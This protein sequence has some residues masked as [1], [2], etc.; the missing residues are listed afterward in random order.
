M[1]SGAILLYGIPRVVVGE[2]RSFMGEEALL[3]SRGVQVEVVQDPGCI[4]L[5]D[6]FVRER[7][8][9]WHEDIGEPPPAA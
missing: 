4:A 9:L 3:R 1:C 8:D 5:M 6:A 2:N 7:P